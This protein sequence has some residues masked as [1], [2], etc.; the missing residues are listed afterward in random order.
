MP[1]QLTRLTKDCFY[2]FWA[3]DGS[4]VY[5]IS[6]QSLWAVGATGGTPEKVL[7]NVAQAAISPDGRTLAALRSNGAAYSVWTGSIPGYNLKR[8]DKGPFATLQ[9]L[10]SSY[11]RFSPDGKKLATWLS[12]NGGRSQFWLLPLSEGG[13]PERAFDKLENL[14]QAREFSWSPSGKYIVYAERSGLS[15]GSHLWR[16]DFSH[17][18]ITPVTN[19]VGSELSPSM[20]PNARE[21]AFSSTHMDYDIVRITLDGKMEDVISTPGF[22]V[23]PTTSVEGQFAYVADRSGQPEIWLR[24]AEAAWE[25]PMVTAASFGEDVTTSIFDAAFSPDGS[26]IAYRRA[27]A[28]DESIWISTI[29]GDPPVRL[30]KEPA[31]GIQRSPTWSPDGNS[32]AYFTVRD[33]A[34]V[35]MRARVGGIAEPVVLAKD[36]GTYPR[37]SPKGDWI[38]SIGKQQGLT[39]ISADG[40]QRKDA[41]T[42]TWL[43]HGWSVDGS[44]VYG[45][46][47][48]EDR[49]LELVSL[50][51]NVETV[52]ADMG[53]YPAAFSYGLETGSLPLRGF[54][55][56]SDGRGFLTSVL[57]PKSDIWVMDRGR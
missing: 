16:A 10:P 21:L 1:S 19:G 22:E 4:R 43:L 56:A 13:E 7:D 57:R 47:R 11:L 39:L 49:R 34:N 44:T 3:P 35:L 51:N 14:P 45:I 8:F 15:H 53:R 42:G 33:G 36:A 18:R 24:E 28:N 27:A 32:I 5:F 12:L 29:A 55:M 54:T 6:E 20:S 17:G 31:G 38:A 9:A 40:V 30:A 23:S 41:G 2:P 48:S 26:R 52:I 37:W 50:R 25:K 46:R